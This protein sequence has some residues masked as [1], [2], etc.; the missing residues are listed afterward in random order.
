MGDTL[1]KNRKNKYDYLIIFLI[2]ILAFGNIGGGVQPIRLMSVLLAPFILFSMVVINNRIFNYIK[3][4]FLVFILY[5]TVSLFWTIQI[6]DGLLAFLY[7][8]IHILLFFILLICFFN[9][10]DA[11][12]SFFLGWVFFLMI[13][14][15]IALIEIIF[16]YH[17]PT[18]FFGSENYVNIDGN[19]VIK[20]F[21]SVTFGNYNTYIMIL[22]LALPF[23]LNYFMLTKSKL[24]TIFGLIIYLIA[25]FVILINASR[26]GVICLFI[27]SFSYIKYLNKSN[28]KIP[29]YF[30]I[31]F[32]F[33]IFFILLR[34]KE[35]L[36]EQIAYRFASG[37]GLFEDTSRSDL[38][39]KGF[40]IVIDYSFL[41]S[42]IGSIH[43]L[44]ELKN[45]P[46]NVPHNFFLEFLIEYGVFLLIP[47][48]LLLFNILKTKSLKD[49]NRDKLYFG[50]RVACII[51]PII[52]IINS[53]YILQPALWVFFATLSAVY[54][55]SKF[56]FK[57]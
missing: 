23:A 55:S 4:Y 37:R 28:I 32:I 47:I 17:L 5:M 44:M 46:I 48:L 49:K 15:S 14:L 45:S 35:I 9:A 42:G 33:F 30:K 20:K 6:E 51:F 10:R 54:I 50:S 13:T 41:G 40:E 39:S 27:I 22:C 12:R 24:N 29:F 53:G 34:Y 52:S 56:N 38:M 26:G 8:I 43:K 18:S 11:L 25:C 7:S 1:V 2:A 19:I 57:Q 31:G 21:S 3:F 36:F 16:D